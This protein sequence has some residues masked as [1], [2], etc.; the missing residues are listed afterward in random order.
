M[1]L[2]GRSIIGGEA[3]GGGQTFRAFDPSLGQQLDPPL[4]EAGGAEVELRDENRRGIWRTVDNQLT[5][6]DCDGPITR[7]E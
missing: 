2:C 3:A 5:K 6:D 1:R 7:L 4:Y